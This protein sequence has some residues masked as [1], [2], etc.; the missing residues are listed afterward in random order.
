MIE[1][2]RGDIVSIRSN[3]ILSKF[4]SAI[5]GKSSNHIGLAISNTMMI[6]ALPLYGVDLIDIRKCCAYSIYRYRDMAGQSIADNAIN[7]VVGY[8]LDRVNKR[9]D[10]GLFIKIYLRRDTS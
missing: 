9:Y 3:T 8:A 10:Q 6:V 7:G 2:K 1:M 4:L 5:T